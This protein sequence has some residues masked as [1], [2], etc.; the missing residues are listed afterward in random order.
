MGHRLRIIRSLAVSGAVLSAAVAFGQLAVTDYNLHYVGDFQAT[1]GQSEPWDINDQN[2]IVGRATLSSGGWR[3]MLWDITQPQG[4]PLQLA[5]PVISGLPALA[6]TDARS[7]NENR[8]VVGYAGYGAATAN[9]WANTRAVI[10]EPSGGGY[11][12]RAIFETGDALEN[13]NTIALSIEPT[14]MVAG[15]RDPEGGSPRAWVT[16]I[17]GSSEILPLPAATGPVT[18]FTASWAWNIALDTTNGHFHVVGKVYGLN[19]GLWYAARWTR[20]TA[21]PGTWTVEVLKMH[22][23]ANGD[24]EGYGVNALGQIVGWFRVGSYARAFLWKAGDGLLGGGGAGAAY[25][26]AFT[27]LADQQSYALS[28]NDSERIVGSSQTAGGAFRPFFV[29][30][31]SGVPGSMQALN[32]GVPDNTRGYV[33]GQMVEARAIANRPR[34]GITWQASIAMVGKSSVGARNQAVI[35]RSALYQTGGTGNPGLAIG[36]VRAVVLGGS[37]PAGS[38]FDASLG[39]EWA[40]SRQG[41]TGV[42]PPYPDHQGEDIQGAINSSVPLLFNGNPTSSIPA[43]I[44][45]LSD[46]GPPV[47]LQTRREDAGRLVTLTPAINGY[48]PKPGTFNVG[49]LPTKLI[50]DNVTGDLGTSVSLR[51]RLSTN[52]AQNESIQGQNVTFEVVAGSETFSVGGAVTGSDGF[53]SLNWTI[54][55]RVGTGP[56]SIVARF[57]GRTSGG[58][59]PYYDGSRSSPDGVL[60]ATSTTAVGIDGPPVVRPG[61]AFLLRLSVTRT[62]NNSPIAG[63]SLS[64]YRKQLPG[65]ADTLLG[66]VAVNAGGYGQMLTTVPVGITNADYQ[67]TAVYA[68]LANPNP[69]PP[70]LEKPGQGTDTVQVRPLKENPRRLED[71][72]VSSGGADF[73]P[74]NSGQ[75]LIGLQSS[76]GEPIVS[77][78]QPNWMTNLFNWAFGGFWQ[79]AGPLQAPPLSR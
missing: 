43:S 63:A 10:W 41:N 53:A 14:G 64:V 77:D 51:A 58:T 19:T 48:D 36:G 2:M 30:A 38:S 17:F 28:I 5:N 4:L 31:S 29:D 66:T 50:V 18:S 15:V 12:S 26:G 25:L 7:I 55:P 57:A 35:A 16:D 45:R 79:P 37:I 56:K 76:I 24:S 13:S 67:Y 65:G 75:G 49:N 61:E 32:S 33:S 60:T 70:F 21:L 68:G 42:Q 59:Y 34:V 11:T 8:H 54:D 6:A 62:S 27:N 52:D 73:I 69:P 20:S 3:A 9:Y 44:L 46:E 74:A 40:G 39:T 47:S 22:A 78:V 72:L 23:S 1:A 71:Y